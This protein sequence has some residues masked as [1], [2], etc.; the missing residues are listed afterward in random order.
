MTGW[1]SRFDLTHAVGGLDCR[2]VATGTMPHVGDAS[3]IGAAG[4]DA[5]GRDAADSAA[6]ETHP[7]SKAA[8]RKL[9]RARRA[10]VTTN[11]VVFAPAVYQF[12]RTLGRRRT[13]GAPLRVAT[14][15][16]YGD[17]PDTGH[18]IAELR[19]AGHQVLLP[20]MAD[21]G[22]AW[23]EMSIDS[24][25]EFAVSPPGIREPQG[26]DAGLAGVHIVLVPALAVTRAGDRLG[27]GGGF[28]DRALADVPRFAEGGP[29]LVAVVYA[30]EVLDEPTWPTE[31]HDIRMD[32]I[33]T[34][35]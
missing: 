5:A 19:T 21:D 15:A 23:V 9:A 20:R 17:E 33:L 25:P 4:S 24:E 22:L 13:T 12:A 28:Y 31:S 10:K 29:L 7:S 30:H 2:S 35:D 8:T 14:Y 11:R 27:Q 18:L 34:V 26:P 6:F 3:G 16:S 32:A 1:L